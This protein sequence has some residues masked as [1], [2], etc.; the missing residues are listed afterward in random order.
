LLHTVIGASV[1]LARH[2]WLR[3]DASGIE[4]DEKHDRSGGLPPRADSIKE[5]AESL[6]IELVKRRLRYTP[7]DWWTD[8]AETGL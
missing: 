7:I 1:A 2:R 3:L 8:Q 5:Y 4:M 6:R